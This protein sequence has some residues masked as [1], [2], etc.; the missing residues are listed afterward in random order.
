MTIGAEDEE[1]LLER[2]VLGPERS[3]ELLKVDRDGG[4]RVITAEKRLDDVCAIATMDVGSLQL[5]T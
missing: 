4:V 3:L 5:A 2:L 1:R